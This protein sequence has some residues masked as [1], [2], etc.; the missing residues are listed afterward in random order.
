MLKTLTVT[1]KSVDDALISASE[2]L[3]KDRSE[4]NYEI[5]EQKKGFLGLGTSEVTI[6]VTYAL[7]SKEATYDF[8]RTYL[9]DMGFNDAELLLSEE[10]DELRYSI[11]GE[12]L[13]ILIGRHGE[14]LDS[15]QYLANLVAGKND[16]KHMR[17]TLDVENYREKREATLTTLARK[18]ASYVKRTRRNF[19]FEPMNPYERR[20]IHST[21]QK[22]DGVSTHSIGNG[23]DRRVVLSLN[24]SERTSSKNESKEKKRSTVKYEYNPVREP[25]II[26]KA[27]SIEDI[28]LA[29]VEDTETVIIN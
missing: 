9:D 15:M 17:V 20:I 18:M 7:D 16:E 12:N 22:I 29:D 23:D 10:N 6:E 19:T 11:S 21:V 3:K 4:L 2:Q 25:R 24:K 26:V 27:K 13:G 5:K 28:D 1:A 14:M 8:L